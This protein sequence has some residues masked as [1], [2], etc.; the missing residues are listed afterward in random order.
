MTTPQPDLHEE[1]LFTILAAALPRVTPPQGLFDRVLAEVRSEAVVVPL[2]RRSRVVRHRALG[3]LAAAAAV[4]VVTV[5]IWSTAGGGDEPALRAVLEGSGD[6]GVTGEAEL[7]TGDGG[8]VHVSLRDV[9]A[10]PAGH[11]YEVWVLR[12][13][14]EAME[15]VGTFTP[16][17]SDVDLELAVP[18]SGPYAA[19][20]VSIEEDGGPPEHS[21]TSLATGAFH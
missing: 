13:G 14:A 2:Q 4:L 15:P 11:H 1:E 17:A 6:S 5:G 7:F 9:P 3:A 18:G 8:R 19:V 20:D 21:G 10:A 16:T 12:V